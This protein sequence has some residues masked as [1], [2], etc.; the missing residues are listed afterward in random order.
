MAPSR[1]KTTVSGLVKGPQK[2]RRRSIQYALYEIATAWSISSAF[3]ILLCQP[4]CKVTDPK[5]ASSRDRINHPHLQSRAVRER[6]SDSQTGLCY[7]QE[8]QVFER[9]NYGTVTHIHVTGPASFRFSRRRFGF[10][11]RQHE[12]NKN[13]DASAPRTEMVVLTRQHSRIQCNTG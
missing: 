3:R 12:V 4:H 8:K 6:G 11:K 13:G 5:R 2:L 7:G 10:P 9:L 1:T